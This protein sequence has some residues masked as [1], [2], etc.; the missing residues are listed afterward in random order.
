MSEPTNYD[1]LQDQTI[2]EIREIVTTTYQLPEG[3]EY[4][5]PVVDQPMNDEQWQYVT[6][7]NGDG[8][9]DTGGSPYNLKLN[10]S[11]ANTNSTNTML[12]TVSTVTKTAEAVLRGFYH[13]LMADKELSFPGVMSE[14][15]YYVVLQYDPLGHKTP[16]GPIS[17]KVVTTLDTTLG[18]RQL[19]LWVLVRQPN[20]LLT[21]ATIQR[22]LPRVVPTQLVYSEDQLPDPSKLVWGSMYFIH[23]TAEI[24]MAVGANEQAGGPTRWKNLT[25]PEWVET[26]SSAFPAFESGLRAARRIVGDRVEFRGRS[27]R[28]GGS[29][30]AAG[31]TYTLV[32]NVPD[33]KGTLIL[34]AGS[35]S[36]RSPI[37][38]DAVD[39]TKPVF[40]PKNDT[41]YID[42][43]G[44]FYYWK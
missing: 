43:T 25:S 38:M 37:A 7:A 10:G 30:F 15:T 18:K 26:T 42:L 32:P 9:F 21:D 13:R 14:T 8:I 2:D 40:R 41:P 17:V 5:Y 35:D 20:Q 34:N 27:A 39:G 1:M 16:G 23:E 24:V 36:S 19:V 11:E 4:S 29:R 31:S 28:S 44:F 6:L 33:V 3:T 12:L 22:Y